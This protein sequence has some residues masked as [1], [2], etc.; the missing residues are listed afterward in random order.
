MCCQRDVVGDENLEPVKD[1]LIESSLSYTRTAE[2]TDIEH[3]H[4]IQVPADMVGPVNPDSLFQSPNQPWHRRTS[5]VLARRAT[6][7]RNS[8]ILLC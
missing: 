8:R 6:W 4:E 5:R 3:G 1:A 2:A 7:L